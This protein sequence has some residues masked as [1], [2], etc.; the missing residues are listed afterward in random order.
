[1]LSIGANPTA[2]SRSG[3]V[4][5]AGQTV[6]INQSSG[7]PTMTL[8]KTA[9]VFGAT[10]SGS[11]FGAQTGSQV[12][13]LMQSGLPG[14][15]TWTATSSAPWL[16]VSPASGTGGAALTIGLRLDSTVPPRGL[17]GQIT[18]AL[19]GAGDTV[20]PVTVTLT[21]IASSQA[22]PPFGSFDSPPNAATGLSGS[23]AVT[24]WALDDVQVSRVTI[25]RN[26]V[27][28]ESFGVDARCGGVANV[29]IGDAVF[30][31]G[32]RPDVQGVFPQYPVSSRAGWG[33]LLLTNFLTNGGNGTFQLYAYASDADG[34]TTLL[35]TKTISS[36][37]AD[38]TAPFGAIDTPGQGAVVSGVVPN[39]GWVL[40]RGARRSDPPGGGTV[41]VFVDGAPVGAPGGWTSRSDLSGAFP[42]SQYS[43]IDTALGVF[44]LDTTTLSD[45]VHTISWSAT[46]TLGVTSGVGSR[47]FTVSNEGGIGS[48]GSGIQDLGSAVGFR[49]AENAEAPG[50]A[51]TI[52]LGRVGFDLNA[53]PGFFFPDRDGTVTIAAHELDRI[54]LQLEPGAT[55]VMVTSLGDKP[56]PLGARIDLASGLFTW[57]PGPGFVGDYDFAFGDRRV[58]ITIRPGK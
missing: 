39:F 7:L 21:E 18:I 49:A 32:A 31:D 3:N 57:A 51:G 10:R 14:T 13:R 11:A 26:Q 44:G 38:A 48:Q 22:A 19:S 8:D 9:L 36:D 53:P 52:L 55:G 41:T 40:S 47:F 2:S 45:G 43:G 28:G 29:Y 35:G 34:H 50:G 30:A 24:G 4:M 25:C 6:T 16:T 33:Y 56:L 42:V 17:T 20:G 27:S 37:N 12:V 23:I 46:D 1:V 54:E 5:I 58:R 15:V